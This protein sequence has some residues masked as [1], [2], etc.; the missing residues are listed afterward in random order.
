MWHFIS[1]Y[2]GWRNWAVFNYNSIFENFFILLYIILKSGHFD[3]LAFS[4]VWYFILFSIFST[5][6]GYLINDLADRDLDKKHNKANTFEH[7]SVLRAIS[8]VL[9]FLLLSVFFAVPFL[10]QSWFPALWLSWIIISSFYSL[11][12]LRLKERGSVGLIFVVLA[13]RVIPIL[14]IFAS[15]P[16]AT[17]PEIVVL[18]FYAL[19]RGLA[20][21]M[22]H[23]IQDYANDIQTNTK[24]FAVEAGQ[25][26]SSRIFYLIL[27]VEKVLLLV[28]LTMFLLNLRE[29]HPILFTIY[30]G[31]MMFYVLPYMA[32]LY[33]RAKAA[34]KIDPNPFD[35]EKRNIFQYLH[36]SYPSVLLALLMNLLLIPQNIWYG[37]LLLFQFLLRRLFSF[38]VFKESYLL[39]AIKKMV[40]R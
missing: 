32:S 37:F 3:L 13:Q 6:Y 18:T 12:P 26:K 33:L 8:V 35:Q 4:H 29:M 19:L 1:K 9:F 28:I 16:W 31:G 15:F 39:Q 30:I 2:L 24:T 23:Q 27:E 38:A 5:T 40:T 14:L 36:H 7:D 21:D 34:G 10:K 25:T 11:P 17:V 20:S 22:N